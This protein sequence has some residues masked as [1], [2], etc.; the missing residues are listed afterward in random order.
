[1]QE[2]RVTLRLSGVD[3]AGADQLAEHFRQRCPVFTTLEKA[4]PIELDVVTD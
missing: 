1:M 3:A 2:F 4:A